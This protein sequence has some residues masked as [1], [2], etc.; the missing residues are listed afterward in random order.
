M[1]AQVVAKLK[2]EQ[3][4]AKPAVKPPPPAPPAK[5]PKLVLQGI[6]SDGKTRE[7]LINGTDVRVGDVVEDA[8]VVAIE[9]STVRLLWNERE[10]VVRMP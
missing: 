6:S 4:A 2:A 3:A 7:A 9:G 8:R 10:L 1:I 5:P